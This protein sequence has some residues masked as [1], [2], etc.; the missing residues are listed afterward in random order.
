MKTSVFVLLSLLFLSPFTTGQQKTSMSKKELKAM[1]IEKAV[2]DRHLKIVINQAIPMS[3]AVVHL[4]SDYWL[5][6]RNDSAYV[7]LPY[8]GRAYSVPYESNGGFDF[9]EKRHDDKI[10]FTKKQGYSWQFTVHT[11]DDNYLF[12][13]W[14]S[15]SGFASISVTCNNR[16]PI[17]YYGESVLSPSSK[18]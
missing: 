13:V 17:S 14:I 18:Q 2:N 10:T 4:T 7:Y 5:D 8:Y 11:I 16:Q 6:L 1:H 9:A 12:N 3:H 15:L